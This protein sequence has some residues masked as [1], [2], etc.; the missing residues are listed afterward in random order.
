MERFMKDLPVALERVN[1]EITEAKDSQ[2]SSL[3][4]MFIGGERI[5][6]AN[7]SVD[8][9]VAAIEKHAP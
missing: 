5:V 2:I 4:T 7:M 6:G 9:L 3:P 1:A 8:Q